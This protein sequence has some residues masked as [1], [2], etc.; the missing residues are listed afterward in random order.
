MATIRDVAKKADTS[1]ATVSAVINKSAFVS[2]GLKKRVEDAIDELDFIPNTLASSLKSKRSYLIGIL[3]SDIR[4]IYYPEFYR[5]AEDYFRK[6]GYNLIL[7]NSDNDKEL[8]KEYLQILAQKRVDGIIATISNIE[9]LDEAEFYSNRG[10]P[11]VVTEL[12]PLNLSKSRFSIVMMDSFNGAKV[13]TQHLID[14]GYKKIAVVSHYAQ[15]RLLRERID[16]YIAALKQ[17]KLEIRDDY[18]KVGGFSNIEAES[19]TNELLKNPDPP[20]AIFATNNRMTLGVLKVLKE[21]NLIIPDDIALAGFDDFEW[22]EFLDPPL[23]T[24]RQPVYETGLLSARELLR[25]IE[26]KGNLKPKK[27]ELKTELIIR[28]STTRRITK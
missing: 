25:W 15:Y 2:D 18:I 9:T 5:G 11:F 16:G 10:I 4:N 6:K 12:F 8:E 26:K 14:N 24:V 19:L 23:T 27:I 1:I 13:A 20:E 17:N 7:C 28:D 21:N 3:I 22:A